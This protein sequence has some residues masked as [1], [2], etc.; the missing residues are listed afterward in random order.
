MPVDTTLPG[1]LDT[2]THA[3]RPAANTVGTGA[4]YSCTDHNLIY[5]SN[6]TTWATWAT[7]GGGGGA[8]APDAVLAAGRIY[9]YRSFS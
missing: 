4:I 5:Q 6:G 7:L 9:A 2:G 1:L 3:A 8:A